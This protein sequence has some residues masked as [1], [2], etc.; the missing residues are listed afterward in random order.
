MATMRVLRMMVEQGQRERI[1]LVAWC[2]AVPGKTTRCTSI[3]L[4]APGL[5]L[6]QRT[7]TTPLGSESP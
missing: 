3:P 7:G 6:T 4:V 2:V 1:A 5:E